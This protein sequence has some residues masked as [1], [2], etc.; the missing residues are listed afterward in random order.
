M[1]RRK[2]AQP[3]S[4]AS[5]VDESVP[6]PP[7]VEISAEEQWR[8]INQTGVLHKVANSAQTSV[9]DHTATSEPSTLGD[10]LFNTSLYTIP[11]SSLLLLM[12]MCASAHS[13]SV[14]TLTTMVHSLVQ[15]QYSHEP[16]L[17]QI[18]DRMVPGVPSQ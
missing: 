2:S 14:W 7:L 18:T 3:N 17:Q 9:V 5:A 8:L 15:R 11:A 16:T 10:E 12:E 4:T 1:S 6:T 13:A